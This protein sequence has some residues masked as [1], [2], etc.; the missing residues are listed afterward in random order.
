MEKPDER[1]KPTR[2]TC[3]LFG[4]RVLLNE[5]DKNVAQTLRENGAASAT[6]AAIHRT[7]NKQNTALLVTG[8]V[9]RCVV[10]H[11]RPYRKGM[12]NDVTISK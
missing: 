4:L 12:I 2:E 1:T 3:A 7:K 10:V 11:A 8:Q 9:R 6:V 5:E